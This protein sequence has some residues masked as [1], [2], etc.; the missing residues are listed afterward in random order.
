V[1]FVLISPNSGVV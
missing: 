1:A